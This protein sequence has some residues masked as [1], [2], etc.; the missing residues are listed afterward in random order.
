MGLQFSWIEVNLLGFF[1]ADV[2]NSRGKFDEIKKKFVINPAPIASQLSLNAGGSRWTRDLPR[3]FLNSFTNRSKVEEQRREI[4]AFKEGNWPEDRGSLER[5][6]RR[7]ARVVGAVPLGED[8]ASIPRR[9]WPDLTVKQPEILPR[10]RRDRATIV[11]RSWSWRSVCCRL[12]LWDRFRDESCAIA[13]RSDRDCGVLPRFFSVVGLSFWWDG[14]SRSRVTMAV[15]SRSRGESTASR[16]SVKIAMKIAAKNPERPSRDAL[17]A[18]WW[19]SRGLSLDEDR[20]SSALP[21]GER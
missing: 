20:T 8:A 16:P 1:L 15:R 18:I 21:R 10:S 2:R 14:W 7:F 6:R 12:I 19:R 3:N 9:F 4:H 11:R 13:A 17:S 5:S